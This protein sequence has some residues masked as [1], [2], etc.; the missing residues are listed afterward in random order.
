MQTYDEFSS[1]GRVLGVCAKFLARWWVYS[2]ENLQRAVQFEAWSSLKIFLCNA[3][4][5]SQ[6]FK[7]K[8]FS[9]AF[10]C[11]WDFKCL[12]TNTIRDVSVISSSTNFDSPLKIFLVMKISQQWTIIYRSFHK[13][14]H[15]TTLFGGNLWDVWFRVALSANNPQEKIIS[16]DEAKNEP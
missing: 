14:L 11:K 9:G 6:I 12:K 2:A 8:S 5:E 13:K 10:R 1:D 16:S 4:L 3:C 7:M 15:C